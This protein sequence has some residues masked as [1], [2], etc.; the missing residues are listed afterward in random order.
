MVVL[1]P[2]TQEAEAG[3]PHQPGLQL[4]FQDSWGYVG[5]L[6]EKK[7][8]FFPPSASCPFSLLHPS[9]S[10]F[11]HRKAVLGLKLRALSIL[12]R[13][14]LQCQPQ[15]WAFGKEAQEELV[16]SD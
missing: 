11:L 2:S 6:F 3:R 4:E 7:K 9:G 8:K 12:G 5:S 15:P 13:L 10:L 14:Q 1:N 16:A